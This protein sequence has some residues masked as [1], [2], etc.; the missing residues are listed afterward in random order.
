MPY[1]KHKKKNG[2]TEMGFF[3]LTKKFNHDTEEMT[4]GG[5]RS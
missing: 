3:Y 5:N 2:E 4:I 1:Y